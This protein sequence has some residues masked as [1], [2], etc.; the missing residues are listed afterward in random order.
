MCKYAVLGDD[1]GNRYSAI[2]ARPAKVDLYITGIRDQ[3]V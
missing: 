3:Q 1:Y 2:L